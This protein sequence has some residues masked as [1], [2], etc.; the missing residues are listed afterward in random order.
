MLR[1]KV[2]GKDDVQIHF[3]AFPLPAGIEP[4]ALI[5]LRRKHYESKLKGLEF[6]DDAA[7]TVNGLTGH[8]HVF[9]HVPEKRKP[10]RADEVVW[11]QGRLGLP[12]GARRR[13]VGL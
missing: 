9:R 11:T 4:K 1:F 12:A 13:G 2:P 3:V 8:R 6:L 10:R 7:C 5:G